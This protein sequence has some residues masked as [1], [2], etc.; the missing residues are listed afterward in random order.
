MR[1]FLRKHKILI[2]I[3]FLALV[4]RLLLFSLNFNH[5]GSLIGAIHGDDGY[6]ELSQGIL[7]GHG[8][9]WDSHE[10]FNPNPLR[11]PLWP[12][13]IAFLAKTFDSYWAVLIFEIL[14]GSMIPVIGMLIAKKITSRKSIWLGTGILLCLEPYGVLL[15]SILYTETMFT[16]L[17][18]LL[19]LFVIR[20]FENKSLRNTVWMA[21]FLALATLVKPTVQYLPIVLALIMLY[22]ARKDFNRRIVFQIIIFLGL[23]CLT[24]APWLYRNYAIFGKVGISAQPAFNLYVY[25]VPTVLSYD[26]HTSFKTEHDAL[27]EGKNFDANTINLSNSDYYKDYAIDVISDHK[28][29]LV[30]SMGMTLVTFFTHD[31]I[32]T[33]FQ[34][35]GII[36]PVTMTKPA[37]AL[38]LTDPIALIKS[39]FSYMK[40]Y[41]SV[42]LVARCLW[43]LL[44]ILFFIGLVQYVRK[45]KISLVFITI[46]LLVAYFALT[47]AINGLGVNARFKVPINTF[48]FIFALYGLFTLKKDKIQSHICKP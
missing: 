38:L 41:G 20:Y 11:T 4:G 17:F 24:M 29:A 48:I 15:S 40:G 26:N 19:V 47:T 34:N 23:F 43:I 12:Y 44:T 37:L 28:L 2:F 22:D 45:E 3:F 30:R 14:I 6:Y 36:I 18:L 27:L 25:L 7:G 10:P 35:A 13:I 32:L 21:M 39:I 8:F 46:V 9:T 16:F 5:A 42:V 1:E 31:G 33:V